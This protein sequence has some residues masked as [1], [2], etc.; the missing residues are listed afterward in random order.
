MGA[1]R[2]SGVFLIQIEETFLR[3]SENELHQETSLRVTGSDC[4]SKH[5]RAGEFLLL[6]QT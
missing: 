2:G 5:L 6:E 1:G 3:Q 4:L